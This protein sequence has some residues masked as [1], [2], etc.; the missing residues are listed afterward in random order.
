MTAANQ[1][2]ERVPRSPDRTYAEKGWI[3]W[4][5]W[6]GVEVREVKRARRR[7][8][9]FRDFESARAF[10]HALHLP[11]SLAWPRYLNGEFLDI[12][13]LPSDIP[14]SPT[15]HYREQWRGWGDWL[16][17]GTIAPS[18]RK[19]RSFE[20]ARIFA[21]KLGLDGG[22]AWRTWS[23]SRGNRP[24]DIPGSPDTYY[25]GQGWISWPDF[26]QPPP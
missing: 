15:G 1:Q 16:G 13:P 5:D 22:K 14:R 4:S 11:G 2:P 19:F 12:P 10:V 6:L 7:V 24:P 23:K 21:R 20:D 18:D 9:F 25:R 3:N 17:T 26:L 8:P